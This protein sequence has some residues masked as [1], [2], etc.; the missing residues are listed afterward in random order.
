MT[1]LNCS[2][3]HRG[4][5]L[6]ITI[7]L[8]GGIIAAQD[9]R[10]TQE[11]AAKK[12]M[13]DG[14]QLVDEG[15]PASLRKA[16][17]KFEAARIAAHSLNLPAGEAA[18]LSMIGYAYYQLEQNQKA[19]EKYT[20][21]L[22][23][24]RAGG[25]KRG[26]ATS[27]VHL[28][29]IN[30]TLGEL[31]KALDNYSQAVLL[32]R[33]AGDRQGEALA[34]ST[35]GN[36]RIGLGKPEEALNYFNKSLETFRA[37]GFREGEAMILT[38]LAPLYN[39][40][41]Q[42]EKARKTLEQ[43]LSVSRAA[44]F[45]HGEAIA[46]SALGLLSSYLLQLQKAVEYNEQA[47]PLFRAEHDRMG[48]SVTLHALC[49]TYLSYRDYK[50]GFDYCAQAQE[51]LRAIGDRQTEA[52]TLKHIAIGERNRGNLGA[53]QTAIESAI[54]I[55]ES[56]RTKV[57]NPEYRLS[58]FAHSQDEYEFYVDLLMLLHKQR[59]NDGYEVKAFQATERARAR[60]LLDTLKEA[61]AD[62]RQG[63]DAALLEREREIQRLLNARAQT[64]MQLLSQ[65]HSEVQ[66][67]AI[68]EEIE[69]LIKNLQQVETEIRQTSPHYAALMQPRP[70]TLKEIQTQVLDSRHA[71]AGVLT[72]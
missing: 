13:I 52:V 18:M 25:E 12:L 72:R 70:L 30:N 17:E 41:G 15:S 45:R 34:L 29:L 38:A 14:L 43:A 24:F 46:L 62:I 19:I 10:R 55:I 2:L 42:P 69:T 35:M 57:I 21:S 65:P 60:S 23:L 67:T 63:V 36:L 49:V 33:A 37:S 56:V 7:L 11:E 47:L 28:G 20:E 1:K 4:L 59:P 3:L 44:G 6:L 71:A 22:P 66:A 58:Y 54:A 27:L 9:T 26:E 48:E 68:A 53:A 40:A 64:Q 5:S 32:F 8:L 39:A 50:K 31:Q 16:I 61:N 51:I